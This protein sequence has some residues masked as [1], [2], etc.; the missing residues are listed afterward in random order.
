MKGGKTGSR[1]LSF[2]LCTLIALLGVKLGLTVVGA[3]HATPGVSVA[4]P[5]AMAKQS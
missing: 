5:A 1:L 2:A 3:L 4:V